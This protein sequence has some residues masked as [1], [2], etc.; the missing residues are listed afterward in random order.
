MKSIATVFVINVCLDFTNGIIYVM[1]VM[2]VVVHVL[3]QQTAWVVLQDTIGEQLM[4]EGVKAAQVDVQIVIQQ[5]NAM[6]V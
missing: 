5:E 1:H 4:V 2:R 3:M 6:D